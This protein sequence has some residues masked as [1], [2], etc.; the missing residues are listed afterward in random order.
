MKMKVS[1]RIILTIFLIVVIALCL[2]LLATMFRLIDADY[3][4]LSVQTMLLGNIGF[5]ILYAAIFVVMI[6]VAFMLMF[7]GIKKERA[8]TAEIKTFES[9][10]V[11]IAI[12]A[13]EELVRKYIR[14]TPDI[15]LEEV[16]VDYASAALKIAMKV[17][18]PCNIS[19]PETTE[20][21]QNGLREYIQTH[22]GIAVSDIK[23]IVSAVSDPIK[24]TDFSGGY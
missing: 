21:A 2:F 10:R 19:I 14:E 4:T 20:L 1:T 11:S 9:G 13:L 7:F 6:V 3:L 5:K 23:M 24:T 12:P 15:S 16:R 18:M 22:S 8:K 17:S